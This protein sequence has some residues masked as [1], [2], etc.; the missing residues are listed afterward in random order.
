MKRYNVGFK[1]CT[2]LVEECF[3]LSADALGLLVSKEWDTK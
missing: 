2:I 1:L 3:K